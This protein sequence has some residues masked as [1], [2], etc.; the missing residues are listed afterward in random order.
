M[1]EFTLEKLPIN[2]NSDYPKEAY[3]V[4]SALRS[5]LVAGENSGFSN[6]YSIDNIIHKLSK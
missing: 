2:I 1:A 4:I 6:N 5:A 3:V